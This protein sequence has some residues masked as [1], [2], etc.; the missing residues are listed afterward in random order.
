M[1]KMIILY[2]HSYTEATIKASIP[3]TSVTPLPESSYAFT[4]ISSTR[5]TPTPAVIQGK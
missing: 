4:L 5:V 3:L 2:Y 1:I